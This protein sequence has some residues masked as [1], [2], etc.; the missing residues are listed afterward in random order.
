MEGLSSRFDQFVNETLSFAN[1]E[2]SMSIIRLLLVLYASLAAPKLPWS[3]LKLLDNFVFRLAVLFMVVWTANKDPTT[4]LLIAVALVV[5]MNTLA[6]RKPFE[7]FL[8]EQNTNVMPSCLGV[9]MEDLLKSFGGDRK[10]L[11][12]ALHNSGTPKNI[13]VNDYNA[14]L[15]ATY[16]INYGFDINSECSAPGTGDDMIM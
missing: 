8:I 4:A 15:L 6:G 7:T 10:E 9:K 11:D 16:L 1:S 14:P 3:I 5:T 13:L 2:P 12:Q